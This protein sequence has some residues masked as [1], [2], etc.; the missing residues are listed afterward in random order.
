MLSKCVGVAADGSCA[1]GSGGGD[2]SV[3]VLIDRHC[4]DAGFA[5]TVV[6]FGAGDGAGDG[7]SSCHRLLAILV[8]EL[9]GGLQVVAFL[10]MEH[11]AIQ[12][13]FQG[14]LAFRMPGL[15]SCLISF[16]RKSLYEGSNGG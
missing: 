16:R 8:E 10:V 15:P 3:V 7:A 5:G 12:P 2:G 4:S 14:F 6:L 11:S 1:D 9:S 13:R